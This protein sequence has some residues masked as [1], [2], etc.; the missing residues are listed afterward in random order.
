MDRTNSLD[1]NG[2]GYVD[3]TAGAAMRTIQRE[4]NAALDSKVNFLIKVIKF[5]ATEAGFEITNRIELR[6]R[7][8]GR[9]YK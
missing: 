7:K 9:E 8:T 3:P 2:E 4:E 1:F 6:D 5:I